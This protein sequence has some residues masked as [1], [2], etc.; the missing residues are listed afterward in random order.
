[1]ICQ[2]VMMTIKHFCELHKLH[3]NQLEVFDHF[4]H[5]M[6]IQSFINIHLFIEI[7]IKYSIKFN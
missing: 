7:M 4:K 6:A 5:P 1:M 2:K 3:L